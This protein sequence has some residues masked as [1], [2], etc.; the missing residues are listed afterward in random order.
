MKL[1]IPLFIILTFS[2][3]SP[4][5]IRNIT[6]KTTVKKESANKVNI[7][8]DKIE[9]VSPEELS[10]LFY[11]KQMT[12]IKKELMPETVKKTNDVN[13]ADY[14]I[15]I[16]W[17]VEGKRCVKLKNNKTGQIYIVKEDDKNG[18]VVLLYRDYF[19]YR[20]RIDGTEVEI[21]R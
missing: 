17:M 16:D 1:M 4:E 11:D 19:K 9:R 7:T 20:F 8:L 18:N 15:I 5:L 2:C 3:S 13:P 6:E 21:K 12:F 14:T 10:G